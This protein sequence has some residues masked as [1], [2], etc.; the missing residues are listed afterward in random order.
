MNKVFPY[1]LGLQGTLFTLQVVFML[2]WLL[3]SVELKTYFAYI[4][5]FQCCYGH[6]YAAARAVTH[7]YFL[8]RL[9]YEIVG[10]CDA[11]LLLTSLSDLDLQVSG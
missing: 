7:P 10:S 4:A 5:V 2:L 8:L 3:S 11:L 1:E 6:Q 9:P